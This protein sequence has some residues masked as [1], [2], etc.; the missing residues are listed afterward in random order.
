MKITMISAMLLTLAASFAHAERAIEIRET[1]DFQAVA[2]T[3]LANLRIGPDLKRY[4]VRV[5]DC[6]DNISHVMLRV[7][8]AGLRVSGAGA[9]FTDGTNKGYNFT[10]TF[11]AGYDSPWIG[12]DSFKE[13]G[14]CVKAVYV[15]AQS[16]D[17]QIKSRVTVLGSSGS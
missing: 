4:Q 12:I 17:P 11:A 9:T 14:K 2:V 1:E 3:T 16:A 7:A 10:Y 5:R 15:N 6:G 8:D 13:S